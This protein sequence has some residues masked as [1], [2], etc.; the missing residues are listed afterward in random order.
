M[1][2]LR[3]HEAMDLMRLPGRCLIKTNKSDGGCVYDVVPGGGR[4][5]AEIAQKIKAHPQ[6]SPREDGLWPGL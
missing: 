2:R 5:E 3:F 1:T 6:V 4:V